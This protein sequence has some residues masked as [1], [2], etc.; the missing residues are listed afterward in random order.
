MLLDLMDWRKRPTKK[1]AP[2]KRILNIFRLQGKAF[3]PAIIAE[4]HVKQPT[5]GMMLLDACV[6]V[7]GDVYLAIPH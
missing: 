6:L 7:A 1:K 3:P 2:F 5:L 4:S